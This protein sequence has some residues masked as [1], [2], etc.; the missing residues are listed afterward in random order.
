MTRLTAQPRLSVLLNKWYPSRLEENRLKMARKILWQ[1]SS[2]PHPN[3]DIREHAKTTSLQSICLED[4]SKNGGDL[5]F[6]GYAA[7]STRPGLTSLSGMAQEDIT[8]DLFPSAP[9]S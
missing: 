3:H 9:E 2:L 6:R 8:A 5:L 7:P 1:T 4:S